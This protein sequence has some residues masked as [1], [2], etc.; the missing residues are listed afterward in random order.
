MVTEILLLKNS[1]ENKWNKNI[2]NKD[3]KSVTYNKAGGHQNF[4]GSALQ[5]ITTYHIQPTIHLL[6][7]FRR[8]ALMSREEYS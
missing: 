4:L 2:S 6:S 8:T 1:S 5:T 7:T 3:P